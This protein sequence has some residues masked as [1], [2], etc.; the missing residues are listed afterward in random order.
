MKTYA[1]NKCDPTSAWTG[2]WRDGGG[3]D[4]GKPENALTGQISWSD[5]VGAIK[6]PAAL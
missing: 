6:V 1:G 4:A 3:Y 2:L 5:V